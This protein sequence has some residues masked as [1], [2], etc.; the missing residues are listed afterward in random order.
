MSRFSKILG[1]AATL[2][3][4][5]ACGG[6]ARVDG[7]IADAPSS[8]IVVKSLN[9]VID[10]VETK[11]DG[12]FV[13]KVDV[14]K[15]QPEFVYLYHGNTK[16]ASLLL[17]AGDKVSVNADTLGNWSIQ[18]SEESL[19]LQQIEKDHADVMARML[20]ISSAIENEK[21]QSKLLKL[22]NDLGQ[23]YVDYYRKCVKYVLGHSKSLTVVPVFFQYLGENLPVFSQNTDAIHFKSISDSL[24][25]VYP[26]SKYIKSLRDEADKRFGYLELESRIKSARQIGFVDVELPD[27]QGVRKKLSDVDSKVIMLYFWNSADAAQKMFN[28]DMLMPVYKDYHKKGL[29]IYQVSFDP[30]KAR[31]ARVVKEQNLPWINVCDSRGAASPYIASYNL[32]VLPAAFILNNGELVDGKVVDEKSFRKLLDQLLK[33]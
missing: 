26:D 18:G 16:V 30:D 5:V 8:K 2:A 27:T 22:R 7:I 10:T 21:D 3:M 23:E 15:G 19:L 6:N 1:Y 31:W 20:S 11:N 17:E 9:H 12:S 24:A 29:E 28:L 33:K 4:V 14:V 25:L 13:V 32:G